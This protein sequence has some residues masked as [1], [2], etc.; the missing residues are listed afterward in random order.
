MDVAPGRAVTV[1][2][3]SQSAASLAVLKQGRQA[4]CSLGKVG[5]LTISR[6]VGRPDQAATQV[7]GDVEILL[8]LAGL[9]DVAEELR[10]LEKE[11]AKTQKDVDFFNRKLSNEKFVANAPPAVLEKDRGKLQE[12]EE[13]LAIL[14]DSL[15]KIG[16]L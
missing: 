5:E 13:K 10:R 16:C 1:M 3:E 11:I 8:P 2:L 15:A 4:I 12:A 7:V 9:V 14:Q 6:D